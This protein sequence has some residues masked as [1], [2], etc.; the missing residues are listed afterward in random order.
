MCTPTKKFEKKGD[1]CIFPIAYIQP[2]VGIIPVSHEKQR[3]RHQS[4]EA[5]PSTQY[6][7][8]AEKTSEFTEC[9]TVGSLTPS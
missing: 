8:P 2:H 5:V 1:G 6:S 9:L 7:I 4:L 3:G